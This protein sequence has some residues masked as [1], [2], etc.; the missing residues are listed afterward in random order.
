MARSWRRWMLNFLGTCQAVFQGEVEIIP[1]RSVRRPH[2]FLS[3]LILH[4][5]SQEGHSGGC[6]VM[7]TIVLTCVPLIDGVTDHLYMCFFCHWKQAV[8]SISMHNTSVQERVGCSL[9]TGNLLIPRSYSLRIHSFSLWHSLYLERHQTLPMEGPVF[10]DCSF[11]GPTTS[12]GCQL[13]F[14]P[15]NTK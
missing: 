5:V 12:P 4:T 6:L 11:H 2:R 15:L 3:W 9:H 14:W 10:Q 7:L 13:W 8:L 1:S